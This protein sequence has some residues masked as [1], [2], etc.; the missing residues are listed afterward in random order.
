[1]WSST[2]VACHLGP[3]KTANCSAT[4]SQGG[5]HENLHSHSFVRKFMTQRR[6]LFSF[7]F[8]FFSNRRGNEFNT[9][10]VLQSNKPLALKWAPVQ[11]F[12]V[13]ETCVSGGNAAL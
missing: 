12:S 5:F 7:L 11:S 1:M 3:K 8:L 6:G 10:L 4:E 9:I 2:S 13:K